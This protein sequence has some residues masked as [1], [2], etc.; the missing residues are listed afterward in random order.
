MKFIVNDIVR[1]FSSKE[2]EKLLIK[3]L[4]G[5]SIQLTSN[6]SEIIINDIII[7]N[8]SLFFYYDDGIHPIHGISSINLNTNQNIIRIFSARDHL[9]I[10]F[11]S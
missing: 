6:S 4:S 2:M 8:Q 5:L 11:F 1:S 9:H 3:H 7:Q 10:K